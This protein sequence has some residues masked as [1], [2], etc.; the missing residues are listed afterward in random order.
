MDSTRHCNGDLQT[1]GSCR[2]WRL[3]LIVLCPQRL[4]CCYGMRQAHQNRVHCSGPAAEAG[5]HSW[6]GDV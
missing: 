2:A 3:G 5:H 4:T 1:A 6:L